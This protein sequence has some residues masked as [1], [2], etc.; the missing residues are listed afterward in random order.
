MEKILT[1]FEKGHRGCS[2]LRWNIMALLLAMLLLVP[3]V[4][5]P[6]FGQ[7]SPDGTPSNPY[8]IRT[9]AQLRTLAERV[10]A[11]GD[12]YFDP[13]DSTYKTTG[14]AR[15]RIPNG[16]DQ[17]CFKLVSDIKVNEGDVASCD[18]V[19][20]TGWTDWTPIGI[21]GHRF[22]GTFDGDFHIVSGVFLKNNG[23]N[24]T[25]LFGAT[26]NYAVIKNLGVANSYIANTGD[27]TGGIIGD[28][29]RGQVEKCF[30][31]GT[32]VTSGNAT[33]GIIG[34]MQSGTVVTSCFSRAF[35]TTTGSQVGGIVGK[36]GGGTPSCS[37]NN[38]YS[39]SIINALYAFTGGVVGDNTHNNASLANCFFDKQMVNLRGYAPYDQSEGIATALETS[40]MT[41]GSWIP[42]TGFGNVTGGGYYPYI[43]GFSMN[44]SIVL[45]VVPLMLPSGA[46]L[47]DLSSVN[48]VTLGGT[49]QNVTWTETERVGIG[50][51]D[52]NTLHVTGQAY[53]VL[54]AAI[55]SQSWVYSLRFDKQPLLGTEQNP[56][57][58]DN[59]TDLSNF[60]DGINLG[61]GFT[62]KHFA[63]PAFGDNTVFLQTHNINMMDAQWVSIGHYNEK[64]FKGVYDGGNLAVKYWRPNDQN[65]AL[66]R[67]TENATV[68]NLTVDSIRITEN[69]ASLIYSMRGGTVD[70]CHSTGGGS[71]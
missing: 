38:V 11:G 24:G 53:V 57:T 70:N 1:A 2:A 19:K 10:N 49:S 71:V 50:R 36:I 47:S 23:N 64:P 35:V 40:N 25:G 28:A 12:F 17:T 52:G 34:T 62:Y 51:L 32:I 22:N 9:K 6:V 14:D 61:I 8:P 45:S 3:A 37:I 27:N 33:G 16:A 31:S 56:F 26:Q 7:S 13:A 21:N 66:F 30:F 29:L 20:A 5:S 63:V 41:T 48:T 58:I 69:R 4:S 60:R 55:G 54:K 65:T 15:Y 59:L 43:E 39:S 67:Y 46:T 42:D 44:N 68:K 18:G